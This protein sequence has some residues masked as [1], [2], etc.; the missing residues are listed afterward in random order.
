MQIQSTHDRGV[1]AL[2]PFRL[3][4]LDRRYQRR[5]GVGIAL[6]RLGR[7]P[8]HVD[9]AVPRCSRSR[10]DGS[11]AGRRPRVFERGHAGEEY[12]GADGGVRKIVENR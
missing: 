11:R 3:H 9:E 4:F 2:R 10:L 1:Y 6:Q 5:K 8:R 12:L 7:S